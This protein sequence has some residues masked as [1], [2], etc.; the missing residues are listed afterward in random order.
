MSLAAADA[1]A[2][3]RHGTA[4]GWRGTARVDAQ[5]GCYNGT[6]SRNITRYGPYGGSMHRSGSVTC[7]PNT[8]SCTGHRTTTGPNGGTVTRHG[9]VYR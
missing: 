6:C 4:S 8:Q 1:N 7:N 5:G 3:E 2:W 9:T